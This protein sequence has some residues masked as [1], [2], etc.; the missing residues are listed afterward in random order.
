MP[1][2]VRP[3]GDGYY[4]VV[5]TKTGAVL[6]KRTTKDKAEKQV[7]LLRALEADPNWKP[8]KQYK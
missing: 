6:A 8:K 4:K 7:N 1:Y 3:L 5:N 2:A